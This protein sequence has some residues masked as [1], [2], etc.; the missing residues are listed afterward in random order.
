MAW[1]SSRSSRCL[2]WHPP[3]TIPPSASAS[4]ALGIVHT[5]CHPPRAV[6][7]LSH[8][9]HL[10]SSLS[11]PPQLSERSW[12]CPQTEPESEPQVSFLGGIQGGGGLVLARDTTSGQWS[13]PCSVGC[14]GLSAGFQAG[15]ELNTVLLI[16]NTGRAWTHPPA[17][18][19]WSPRPPP[20]AAAPRRQDASRKPP[21]TRSFLLDSSPALTVACRLSSIPRRL[22]ES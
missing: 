7:H 9:Q 14:A 21:R 8:S 13:A 1:R 22:S 4:P 19:A 5:T 11:A 12:R 15:G 20:R 17:P 16:L 3:V 10:P 2:P 18:R 6:L